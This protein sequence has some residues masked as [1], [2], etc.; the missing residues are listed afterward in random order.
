MV[1][2]GA[3]MAHRIEE[4]DQQNVLVTRTKKMMGRLTAQ[5]LSRLV[6]S[7]CSTVVLAVTGCALMNDQ[8]KTPR[9][10][11]EQLLLGQA[12]DRSL[13]P[14]DLPVPYGSSLIMQIAG[15]T[16]DQ[17]FVKTLVGDRLVKAGFQ[18]ARREEDA[19]YRVLVTLQSLGTEQ[20]TVFFG[21]PAVQSTLIPFS[22]PEISLYKKSRQEGHARLSLT[23]FE[24]KTG[25]LISSSPWYQATTFFTRYTVLLLIGFTTTDLYS[26]P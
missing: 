25:R 21:M 14:A 9:T 26:P 5:A 11:L 6:V 13:R 20:G 17:E 18:V 24:Q 23:V 12:V 22:L 10:S 7:L 4:K 15:L 8:S 1:G 16:S 19:Q 2:P 3:G